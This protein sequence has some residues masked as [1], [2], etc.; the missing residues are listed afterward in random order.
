MYS[1]TNTHRDKLQALVGADVGF[2][3]F[4]KV[5]GVQ[6]V[7]EARQQLDARLAARGAALS[8]R[9]RYLL[10]D[11]CMHTHCIACAHTCVYMQRVVSQRQQRGRCSTGYDTPAFGALALTTTTIL[12]RV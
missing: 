3:H 11:R 8:C 5:S 10:I 9:G 7:A 12:E 4:A 2:E 6:A 1:L